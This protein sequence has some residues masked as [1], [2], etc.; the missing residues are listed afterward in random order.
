MLSNRLTRA[1]LVAPIALVAAF[2]I[3]RPGV[4]QNFPTGDHGDGPGGRAA[5]PKPSVGI[6]S[7][8]FPG[9]LNIDVE[10]E[11]VTLPLHKGSTQDGRTVWY[12]VTESSSQSDAAQRGVNYSN[13]LLNAL[14]RQAVQKAWLEQGGLVFQGTVDFSGTRV[15]VPGPN[16]FPP[17]E[18]SPGAVA[19]AKYS[20]LVNIVTEQNGK[21]QNT[22][23]VLNAP[24]VANDTGRLPSVVAID[25]GRRTVILSMLAGFV[26]GQFTLYLHT[27]ASSRLIAALQNDTYA[28]NLNAAPGIAND[29][30]PSSRAAII[31]I[32]NGPRGDDNPERQ[33]LESALLGQ[34]DPFNVAQEQPSDPVHYTPIWDVTPVMWTPAAIVDGLRVQLH[35][36]D[37]VRT[38]ALAGNLVSAMPGTPNAGLGELNAIGA[39]S[40]CP[41]IAVFPGGVP[42]Q[43]GVE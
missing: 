29:E 1:A 23:I 42:F 10:H 9:A 18:Y 34:G 19:D 37:A 3:S 22:G 17:T 39:I 31:P 16:G 2:G 33:G 26:D 28:P 15:L 32:V 27:D 30:P 21:E 20:P 25:Y 8:S 5:L 41:I 40:D 38:E 24:Q 43:G 11:T 7:Y 12:V 14:G 36:Q 13:K 6:F 4:A 35:S